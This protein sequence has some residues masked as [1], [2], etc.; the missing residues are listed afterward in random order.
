MNANTK[1]PPC[2]YCVENPGTTVDHV[3]PDQLFPQPKPPDLLTVPCC[4]Q[5]QKSFKQ[6]EDLFRAWIL[7]GDAGVTEYGKQLW[8]Q[9]AKR[10]LEKDRGLRAAVARSFRHVDM[11]TPAGIYLGKKLATLMEVRRTENFLKKVVQGLFYGEYQERLPPDIP[12]ETSIIS[13]V[14][15]R[16]DEAI[17]F[18]FEGTHCH[19]NIFEYR[20]TRS[21]LELFE[22]FWIMSFFRQQYFV[23][24]VDMDGKLG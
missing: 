6:D 13:K 16:I 14:D 15:P 4:E 1:T 18:T 24:L 20:F 5:C 11:Q 22:S 8:A 12:I 23:A 7:F 19:E 10:A 9:K 2:V 3:I 21:S 17:D